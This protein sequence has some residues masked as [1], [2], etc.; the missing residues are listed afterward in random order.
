MRTAILT[1]FAL[2]AA[3]TARADHNELSAGFGT[4]ALRSSSADAV[5]ADSL[6]TGGLAYAR[7]L[8]IVAVPGLELWAE[9]G[10][11][12]GRASGTM[13]QTVSTQ[14]GSDALVV[15]AR[16]RHAL[17]ELVRATARLDVRATRASLSL[18]DGSGHTASDAGWGGVVQ[19]ALGLELFAT[20][21]R[22]FA[23][24]LRAELGYA[25]TSSVA[26]S[27]HPDSHD[28]TLKLQMTDAS[29]GHLDLG[30]PSFTLALVGGF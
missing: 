25:V 8:G 17:H 26:L 11:D 3:P 12:W 15:G 5:T 21:S 24:G 29:I 28:D 23:F 9:A 18:D 7:E 6:G 16:A 19:G 13:F 27:P 22:A 14:V 10:L 30:G 20:R 1:A 2:C 4:R